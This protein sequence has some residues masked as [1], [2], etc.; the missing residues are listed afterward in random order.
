MEA[1]EMSLVPSGL[2]G[3]WVYSREGASTDVRVYRPSGWPLP[4]SRLPR[5]V[6]EFEPDHHVISRVG[7]PADSRIVREGRWDVEPGDPSLLRLDWRDTSPPAL[8]EVTT[9]SKELLQVR[10]VVGSIE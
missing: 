2:L 7:G 3:R 10:V 1:E 8:I 6:L 5:H 4:P 9:C